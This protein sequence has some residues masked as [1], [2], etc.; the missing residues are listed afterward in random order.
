MYS[1]R[2]LILYILLLLVD[3]RALQQASCHPAELHRCQHLLLANLHPAS[4]HFATPP[5]ASLHLATQPLQ[6]RHCHAHRRLPIRLQQLQQPRAQQRLAGSRRGAHLQ[7]LRL[8]RDNDGGGR[9]GR[10]W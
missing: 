7:A 3:H 8:H 10:G 1:G 2:D 5:L 6:Q 4:L 9:P